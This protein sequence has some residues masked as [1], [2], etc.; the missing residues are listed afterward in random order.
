MSLSLAVT[1]LLI[2]CGLYKSF[3]NFLLAEYRVNG[4]VYSG[5][6][7]PQ[8]EPLAPQLPGH[9]PVSVLVYCTPEDGPT[10]D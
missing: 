1:L 5:M 10:R 8:L 6:S 3:T 7:D 4:G 2:F 9:G